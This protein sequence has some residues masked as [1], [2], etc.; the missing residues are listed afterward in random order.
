[1]NLVERKLR[2]EATAAAHTSVARESDAAVLGPRYTDDALHQ[3]GWARS[4]GAN[5]LYR[6]WFTSAFVAAWKDRV[7]S[8]SN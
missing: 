8:L 3:M 1:M 6:G 4:Y 7:A 5:R 2:H